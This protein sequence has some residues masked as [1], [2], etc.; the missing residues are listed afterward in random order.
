MKSQRLPYIFLGFFLLVLIFIIPTLDC[1]YLFDWDEINFA[2]SSREM[3]LTGDYFHVQINFEPF[4]EKPPLFFWLQSLSMK[5]FGIGGFAARFPNALL[6]FLTPI[7][8][9]FMG[10]TIKDSSFGVL[11]ASI[12]MCGILPNLYFRTGIIDPYFNLFIFT[13]IFF[14]YVYLTR[15]QT[16]KRYQILLSGLFAGLALITKGPVAL[17]LIFLVFFLLFYL[18]KLELVLRIWFYFR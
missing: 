9:F 10:K 15:E 17:L 12:Y 14:G 2:E 18:K 8:L 3:L 6:A 5:I 7:T 1:F 11:W 13:S 16:K 4:H